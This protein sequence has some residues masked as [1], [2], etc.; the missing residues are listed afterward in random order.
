MCGM[1]TIPSRKGVYGMPDYVAD[2]R[3]QGKKWELHRYEPSGQRCEKV[4][5]I[6]E[7]SAVY[8]NKPKTVD[9]M[10]FYRCDDCFGS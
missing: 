6:P 1:T 5:E 8:V 4:A 10:K 9:K 2:A 3:L 7:E